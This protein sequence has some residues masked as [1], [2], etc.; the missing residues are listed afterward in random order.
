MTN[1]AELIVKHRAKIVWVQQADAK[2][3]AKL[4]EDFEEAQRRLKLIHALL[5]DPSAGHQLPPRMHEALMLAW[6]DLP[7][8]QIGER[9]GINGTSVPKMLEVAMERIGVPDKPRL[10]SAILQ[11]IREALEGIYIGPAIGVEFPIYIEGYGEIPD[12]GA[13]QRFC[14]QVKA[15][16]YHSAALK[17]ALTVE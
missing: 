15:Q 6:Q 3:L 1:D 2:S 10:H 4:F 13:W 9:M 12:M 5:Q 16:K 14:E 11:R 7:Y 17:E 8:S